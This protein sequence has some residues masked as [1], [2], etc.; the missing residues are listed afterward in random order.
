MRCPFLTADELCSIYDT[1]PE[2]CRSFP[3]KSPNCFVPDWCDLDCRN[4]KDKCC[5]YISLDDKTK[6]LPADFYRSLDIKCE[7]CTH[8]WSRD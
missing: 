3:S 8:C 6:T 5:N 2:C 1:R 4:C 7:D